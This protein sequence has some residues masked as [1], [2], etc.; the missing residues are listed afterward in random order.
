MQ[1]NTI[2]VDEGQEFLFTKEYLNQCHELLPNDY[3]IY[4]YNELRKALERIDW[5]LVSTAGTT[6]FN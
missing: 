1:W 4:A 6:S 3:R 2:D 5:H